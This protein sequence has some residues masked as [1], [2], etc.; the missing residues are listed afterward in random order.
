MVKSEMF[1]F[2]NNKGKENK[3]KNGYHLLDHFQLDQ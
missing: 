3:Y 2:E 1:S